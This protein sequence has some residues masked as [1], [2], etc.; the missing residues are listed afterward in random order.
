[1]RR[2]YLAAFVFAVVADAVR[3]LWVWLRAPEDTLRVVYAGEIAAYYLDQ[4]IP[5]VVVFTC[6]SVAW[7][8]LAGRRA[9]GATR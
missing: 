9:E 4:F 5:W 3:L 1:M 7:V 8:L 2:N 6:L